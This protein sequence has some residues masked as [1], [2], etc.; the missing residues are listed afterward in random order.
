MASCALGRLPENFPPSPC[1][2]AQ[3]QPV[4]PTQAACASR[5]HTSFSVSPSFLALFKDL[6]PCLW[7]VR[8]ASS[9]KTCPQQAREGTAKALAFRCLPRARWCNLCCFA[10]FSSLIL[11]ITCLLIE[12]TE[13]Q[14]KY[15]KLP[16]VTK[17]VN[18]RTRIQVLTSLIPNSMYVLSRMSAPSSYT[19]LWSFPTIRKAFWEAFHATWDPWEFSALGTPAESEMILF[20]HLCIPASDKGCPMI[21]QRKV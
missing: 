10:S 8:S 19:H 15:G 12:E 1:L 4:Q 16:G 18:D 21:T 9:P 13:T 5:W 17:P 14:R 11:I 2:A 3:G 6:D 7:R 20:I